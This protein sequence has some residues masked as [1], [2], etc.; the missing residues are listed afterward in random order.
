MCHLAVARARLISIRCKLLT[1][2][3]IRIT[4]GKRGQ[5]A[6][7]P[8][9]SWLIKNWSAG[10]SVW[11]IVSGPCARFVCGNGK[12]AARPTLVAKWQRCCRR[13]TN[14]AQLAASIYDGSPT[15]S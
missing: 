3:D 2:A 13:A 15:A 5:L 10:Y 12:L 1:Y 4:D 14:F 8:F 11:S 9:L 7:V 6:G